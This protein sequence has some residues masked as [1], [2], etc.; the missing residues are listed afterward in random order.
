MKKVLFVGIAANRN[1]AAERSQI[2][3]PFVDTVDSRYRIELEAG[4][5]EFVAITNSNG[6]WNGLRRRAATMAPTL[7]GRFQLMTTAS[8]RLPGCGLVTACCQSEP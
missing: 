8:T 7:R 3:F 2:M 1:I 5:T 6:A 4:I